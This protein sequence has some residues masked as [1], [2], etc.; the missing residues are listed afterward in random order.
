MAF[1]REPFGGR[2]ELN[3]VGALNHD[4]FPRANA[5]AHADAIAIACGDLDETTGEAFA[6]C[7]RP[8]SGPY[9]TPPVPADTTTP[10]TYDV[11]GDPRD[12]TSFSIRRVETPSR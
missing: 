12:S 8:A 5:A 2:G 9:K 1:G 10:V 11:T 3:V 4:S 7:L 6:A